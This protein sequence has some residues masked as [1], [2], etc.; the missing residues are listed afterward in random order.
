M[1][2]RPKHISIDVVGDSTHP[3]Y[4][5]HSAFLIEDLLRKHPRGPD[6]KLTRED[7]RDQAWIQHPVLFGDGDD[8]S[9]C[10]YSD[11][12]IYRWLCTMNNDGSEWDWKSQIREHYGWNLG[13]A[14]VTR[15][16]RRLAARTEGAYRRIMRAGRPGLYEV[17][18]GHGYRRSGNVKVY[19]ENSEMAKMAAK[20]NFG[21][22]YPN[23][24]DEDIYVSFEREGCPSE[25]MGMNADTVRRMEMKM[26]QHQENI[27]KLQKEIE[28]L[29]LRKMM[30]Q[31]YS[32]A[33][34]AE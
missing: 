30:I 32:I 33:A 5:K 4:K 8:R 34:V 31:T 20:I 21:A 23:V 3:D 17:S 11:L 9:N 25:L 10:G 22:A 6:C 26:Q 24:D 18:F 13:K 7:Y 27:E 2:R 15:R 28:L 19:A 1:A 14:S 16:S 12:L 29:E